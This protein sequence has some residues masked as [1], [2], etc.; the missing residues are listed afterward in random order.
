MA[1]AEAS[2]TSTGKGFFDSLLSLD[3]LTSPSSP[4]S[5][6]LGQLG[7][8]ANAESVKSIFSINYDQLDKLTYSLEP[9]FSFNFEFNVPLSSF[10][11]KSN[12]F[13][14]IL[15]PVTIT[16]KEVEDDTQSNQSELLN[17]IKSKFKPQIV[18]KED[19]LTSKVPYFAYPAYLPVYYDDP[20]YEDTVYQESAELTNN[21]IDRSGYNY[22]QLKF[23]FQRTKRSNK[24]RTELNQMV[25]HLLKNSW[26]EEKDCLAKLICQIS[27]SQ[28]IEN[29]L[30]KSIITNLTRLH[31]LQDGNKLLIGPYHEALQ[32]GQISGKCE[33]KYSNCR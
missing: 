29:D 5:L 23:P 16:I 31:Q 19:G 21:T 7:N 10:F 3:D 32:F 9:K 2:S 15:V 28:M 6:T 30:I 25:L 17:L 8:I 22:K 1:T 13:A 20:V 24:W 26:L 18:S 11:D 14:T 27:R 33:E 12:V 4:T